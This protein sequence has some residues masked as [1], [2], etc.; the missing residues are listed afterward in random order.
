[1]LGTRLLLAYN[2]WR[3]ETAAYYVLQSLEKRA[4]DLRLA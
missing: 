4:S 2:S 1:M 3:K